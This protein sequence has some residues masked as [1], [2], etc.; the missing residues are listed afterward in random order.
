MTQSTSSVSLANGT[1]VF[2]APPLRLTHRRGVLIALGV[3]YAALLNWSYANVES[4][5][6]GYQGILFRPPPSAYTIASYFIAVIPLMWLPLRL[7]K[8]SHLALWM[9][10]ITFYV[11]AVFF[12]YHISAHDPSD[13]LVL[14]LWIAFAFAGLCFLIALPNPFAIPSLR[15]SPLVFDLTL[16]SAV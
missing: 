1:N 15:I 9:L 10:F 6:F 5:A 12:P 8:P 3:L 16:L 7:A 2:G 13:V 4:V 14:V 11:P